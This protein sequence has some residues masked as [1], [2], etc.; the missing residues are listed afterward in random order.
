MSNDVGGSPDGATPIAPGGP[1]KLG[2][3]LG[4]GRKPGGITTAELAGS[5]GVRFGA[6]GFGA[7]GS[8]TDGSG[9]DGPGTDGSAAGAL[10]VGA[11]AVDGFPV[12]GSGAA[13]GLPPGP[14]LPPLHGPAAGE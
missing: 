9:T 6:D 1:L 13:Q 8:A 3:P 4:L 5:R 12:A 14:G 11:L 7:D 10:A 2:R